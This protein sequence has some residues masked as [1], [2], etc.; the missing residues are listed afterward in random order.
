[1]RFNLRVDRD[2]KLK[3]GKNSDKKKSAN[4]NVYFL[5]QNLLNAK[6]II[7]VY[8]YTGRPED[9]GYLASPTGIQTTNLQLDPSAY[10]EF[11]QLKE[12]DPGHYSLPRRMRI[13]VRFD[14]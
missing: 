8:P 7:K 9:D 2:I 1:S 3:F 11:Y 4:L 6:N 10:S 13:G 12:N 14:F 5:V